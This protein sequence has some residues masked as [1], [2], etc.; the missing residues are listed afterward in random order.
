VTRLAFGS[1]DFALDIAAEHC[2]DSLLLARSTLVIAARVAG[3]PAPLDGVTTAYQDVALAA[4]DAKRARALGFGGKLCIHPSQL[5]PVAQAFGPSDAEIA[6]AQRIVEATAQ[7]G[8]GAV[9]VDG[10]MVDQ[11][12]V[13]RALRMLAR[14][15]SQKQQR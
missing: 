1:L 15:E 4:A 9:A 2:D 5:A 13:E 8:G 10:A 14:A 7:T 11:P 12:V 3:K 6:W